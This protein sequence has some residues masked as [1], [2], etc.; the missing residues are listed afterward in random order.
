[1][2]LSN[3]WTSEQDNA[4][5]DVIKKY[6]PLMF[7]STAGMK[8]IIAYKIKWSKVSYE[9]NKMT[10][11]FDAFKKDCQCRGRWLNHLNPSLNK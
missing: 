3:K 11:S 5:L 10:N 9:F 7:E 4:L 2:E 6:Y 1:M 8:T